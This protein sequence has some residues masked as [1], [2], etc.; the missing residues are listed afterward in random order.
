MTAAESCT[1]TAR[2][3]RRPLTAQQLGKAYPNN[4]APRWVLRDRDGI[5][6]DTVKRRIASLGITELVSR[7]LSPW[8]NP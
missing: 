4:T 1:S 2:N 6:D 3:I 5:Y 8:Q 7:P